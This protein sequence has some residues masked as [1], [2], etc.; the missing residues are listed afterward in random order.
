MLSPM[1]QWDFNFT[2][3]VLW[4]ILDFMVNTRADDNWLDFRETSQLVSSNSIL[5]ELIKSLLHAEHYPNVSE[6]YST[7]E[8]SAVIKCG[9]P[10]IIC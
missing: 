3:N 2:V 4:W 7:S 1:F 5:P 10:K 8:V 6:S 9:L